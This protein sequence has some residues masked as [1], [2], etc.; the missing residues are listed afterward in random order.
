[1]ERGNQYIQLV[2]GLYCKMLTISKQLPTL[3]FG[4]QTSEVWV[5]CFTTAPPWPWELQLTQHSELQVNHYSDLNC[6]NTATLG[7][8]SIEVTHSLLF[9]KLQLLPQNYLE[10]G[11]LYMVYCYSNH[12]FAKREIKKSKMLLLKLQIQSHNHFQIGETNIMCHFSKCDYYLSACWGQWGKIL[13]T[14][15]QLIN[16]HHT[17]NCWVRQIW[18][19]ISCARGCF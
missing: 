16:N 18:Y 12:H 7:Q 2:K 17:T 9:L 14:N 11:W 4:P 1:M 19:L 5:E 6:L 10:V 3:G 8:V 15:T 13:C